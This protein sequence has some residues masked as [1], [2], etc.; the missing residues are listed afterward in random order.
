[1]TSYK[2]AKFWFKSELFK[3]K[4]LKKKKKIPKFDFKKNG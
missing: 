3:K 4:I 1:M 2:N